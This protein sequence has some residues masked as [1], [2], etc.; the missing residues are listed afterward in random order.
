MPQPVR[1]AL[2]LLSSLAGKSLVMREDAGGI[3]CH[4]LHE[5]MREF[6]GLRLRGR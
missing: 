4:R 6:A 5:T 3:A 1:D 2:G